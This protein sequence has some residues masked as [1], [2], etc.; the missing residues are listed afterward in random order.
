MK[1]SSLEKINNKKIIFSQMLEEA[2]EN[3]TD[4]KFYIDSNHAE[5]QGKNK[6]KETVLFTYKRVGTGTIVN[7]SKYP[8]HHTQHELECN[9]RKLYEKGYTQVKIA[10]MLGISQSRVSQVLNKKR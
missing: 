9:C 8:K 3:M 5:I 10:K 7:E 6:D 2:S 1:K 4:I